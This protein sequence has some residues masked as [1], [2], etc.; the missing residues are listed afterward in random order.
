M[1]LPKFE[2]VEPKTLKE[3]AKA[4]ALDGES[5]LLAGGTDL[6][7]NMKH[8]LIEPQRLINLKRIPKLSYVSAGRGGLRIGALTTLHELIT[9]P[10]VQQKYPAIATAG[11]EAGAMAH[12]IMGTVGGNLCQG[13][14]C[15]YYNQTT[16]WRYAKT[17]CYKAGGETCYIVRKPGEC[18]S[19]YSGD[20]APVLSA[21]DASVKVVG[22]DGERAFPLHELY[23]QDGKNPLSLKKGEILKEVLLPAP[24][25]KTVYLKLRLRESIEFPLV[26]LAL[27]L[28]KD[29]AGNVSHARIFLSAVGCGPVQAV[30]SEKALLGLPLDD[31]QIEKISSGV[32]KEISPLRTTTTSPAYKRK[33]A[34]V[35]LQ[36]ALEGMRA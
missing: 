25:G 22:P 17:P 24:T 21:L 1:R 3:A 36:R 6:L 30:E 13:N 14:R 26:S 10:V 4:L 2:Y 12:Q 20:L 29:A 33:A 19:A 9:S 18:H 28:N 5:V 8:R 15:R 23:T 7:V 35:L 34:Q 32:V 31:Q 16:F 27:S 11:K